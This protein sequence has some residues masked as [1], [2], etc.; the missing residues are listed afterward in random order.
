MHHGAPQGSLLHKSNARTV[1]T[2]RIA[3]VA[4]GFAHPCTHAS[5]MLRASLRARIPPYIHACMK[6]EVMHV[7]RGGVGARRKS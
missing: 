5:S 3:G 4:D 2:V 7:H 1:R 6:H